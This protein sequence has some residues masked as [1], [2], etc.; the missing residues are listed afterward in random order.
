MDLLTQFRC[1][2][3]TSKALAIDPTNNR[4]CE[5][6][7]GNYSR[8]VVRNETNTFLLVGLNLAYILIFPDRMLQRNLDCVS[9]QHFSKNEEYSPPASEPDIIKV[10]VS[11]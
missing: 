10:A 9:Y 3:F 1:A 5:M 6:G 4:M 7:F 11:L 2:C 8:P